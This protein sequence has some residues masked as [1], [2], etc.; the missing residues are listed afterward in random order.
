M[1]EMRGVTVYVSD[2]VILFAGSLVP[3]V[4]LVSLSVF[5]DAPEI[6]HLF[7]AYSSG[8]TTRESFH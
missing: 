3:T 8:A 6:P 2:L 7:V 1:H 5:R 4:L